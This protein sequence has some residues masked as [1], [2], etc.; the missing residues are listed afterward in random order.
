M[1]NGAHPSGSAF[2][3]RD[4]ICAVRSAR[5]RGSPA[6]NA[7]ARHQATAVQT[8]AGFTVYTRACASRESI[9]VIS[10]PGSGLLT[11]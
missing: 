4:A 7:L 10:A 9:S 5:E 8:R 2:C 1:T 6:V 11:R 3:A